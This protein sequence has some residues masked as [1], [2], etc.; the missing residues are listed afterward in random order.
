MLIHSE[1]VCDTK[2]GHTLKHKL[3]R[4]SFVHRGP[5]YTLSNN[6]FISR[7]VPIR[8]MYNAEQLKLYKNSVLPKLCEEVYQF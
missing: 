2:N 8:T 1:V 5:R 4:M 6:E 3:M 7:V